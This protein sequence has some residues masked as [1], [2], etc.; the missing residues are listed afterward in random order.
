MNLKN[1][2]QSSHLQL[3]PFNF[4]SLLGMGLLETFGHIS[5]GFPNRSMFSAILQAEGSGCLC[6]HGFRLQ[7]SLLLK[8]IQLLK[9]PFTTEIPQRL[10]IKVLLAFLKMVHFSIHFQFMRSGVSILISFE[11]K[12]L[13]WELSVC[14]QLESSYHPNEGDAFLPILQM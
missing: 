10:Y 9:M 5:S 13:C 6:S 7:L 11:Y 8:I 12:A 2:G 3:E 1:D 14:Y 4:A